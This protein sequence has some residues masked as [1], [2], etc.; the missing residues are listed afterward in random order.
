M[1]TGLVRH[2]ACVCAF[3][4]LVFAG[5]LAIDRLAR[6]GGKPGTVWV[7]ARQ[8][9][10]AA[11]AALPAGSD[12]RVLGVWAGGRVL[13]L[14]AGSLAAP[15]PPGIGPWAVRASPSLLRLPAC[16]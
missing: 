15:L 16:G 9:A 3:L 6:A 10:G 8:D 1:R 5:V 14:H 4:M 11:L 12:V 2:L 7:L 13:Q